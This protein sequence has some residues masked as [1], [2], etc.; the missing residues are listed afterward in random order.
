MAGG[1]APPPEAVRGGMSGRVVGVVAVV[2][3][4]VAFIAG[5]GLGAVV[6]T[7]RPATPQFLVNGNNAPFPPFE[8]YS[9]ELKTFVGFN[10]DFAQEIA[11]ATRRTLVIQ[12]FADFDVLL[13]TIRTGGVDMAVASIT[14][15]DARNATLDFS[16]PYWKA[17][18]AALVKATSAFACA[19]LASCTPAE[20][21]GGATDNVIGVQQATTSELW[22]NKEVAPLMDN[23]VT[24]IKRFGSV[25]T[26]IAALSAGG[27]DI[28][29]I[30]EPVA[31][32]YGKPGSGFKVAGTIP[33]G[34][35]YGVAVANGDPQGLIPII[36]AVLKQLRDSGKW[37]QLVQK[38]FK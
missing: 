16:V 35:L 14:M 27:V 30:D 7:P 25:A 8:N 6:Y 36:N 4:I 33:T 12:N 28:V 13:A 11:N 20:I 24:N 29:I 26:V 17:D 37:D 34:E 10:I 3:A 32:S 2:V 15:T 22:V 9:F 18:Q 5:L 19:N 38:W 1:G 31:Q 21:A 23:N